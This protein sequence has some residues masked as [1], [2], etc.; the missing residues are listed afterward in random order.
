[1]DN[2]SNC[3]ILDN[4]SGYLKC[5]FSNSQVPLFNIPALIGRPMLRHEEL[6]ENYQIKVII[7]NKAN[8]DW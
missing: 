1:M 4:G 6:L 7:N 8:Y 2:K 3:I 5:G